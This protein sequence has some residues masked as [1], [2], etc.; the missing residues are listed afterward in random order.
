M[1]KCAVEQRWTLYE[2][3]KLLYKARLALRRLKKAGTTSFPIDAPAAALVGT[4]GKTCGFLD[5]FC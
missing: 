4:Q 2:A 5:I 3:I 1:P